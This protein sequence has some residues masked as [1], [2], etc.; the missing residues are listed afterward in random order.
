MTTTYLILIIFFPHI[1]LNLERLISNLNLAS[2]SI[3][4]NSFSLPLLSIYFN[5]TF[6]HGFFISSV[7]SLRNP[8][9][10]NHQ[11][12]W[13]QRNYIFK[14]KDAKYA[15]IN[16]SFY[17]HFLFSCYFIIHLSNAILTTFFMNLKSWRRL[18]QPKRLTST[19]I[20]NSSN[21][22]LVVSFFFSIFSN[23]NSCKSF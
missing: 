8:T 5:K 9:N 1:F 17:T 21:F 7:I 23:I 15:I 14:N 12:T 11:T 16:L 3:R 20:I 13:Q 18:L 10:L 6:C 19:F 22:E 4:P 2:W